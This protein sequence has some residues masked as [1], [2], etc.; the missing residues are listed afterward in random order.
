[1]YASEVRFYREI[2][3]IS[4]EYGSHLRS[5]GVLTPHAQTDRGQALYLL[6]AESVTAATRAVFL[7]RA[8]TVAAE[9]QTEKP[10]S[11]QKSATA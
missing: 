10:P 5:I 6:T 7:D 9:P 2:L 4:W 1:M 8:R 3:A 11:C